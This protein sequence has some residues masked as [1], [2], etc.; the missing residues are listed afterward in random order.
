[1]TMSVW[2]Q[3]TSQLRRHRQMSS[4]EILF[5]NPSEDKEAHGRS[6]SLHR[7]AMQHTPSGSVKR[8]TDPLAPA[9]TNQAVGSSADIPLDTTLT[10]ETP[11]PPVSVLVPKSL[12]P[13]NVALTDAVSVNIP[14]PPESDPVVESRKLGANH[15]P[16]SRSPRLNGERQH[17][18]V[19][20]FRPPDN[21]DSR[22]LERGGYARIRGRRML[23]NCDHQNRVR[24][25]GS[26]PGSEGKLASCLA[27]E[28]E[29]KN[30]GKEEE[31][32]AEPEN[33]GKVAKHQ[34]GRSDYILNDKFV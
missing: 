16:E 9:D 33:N 12:D 28:E 24:N 11:E 30:L 4:R 13:T 6:V 10:T 32:V 14:E 22:N 31:K 19:K 29:R 25:Q 17:R 18:H 8:L 21:I 15:K 5:S 26:S 7:K 27:V 2:E 20:K 34:E 23:H 1:M 3:R